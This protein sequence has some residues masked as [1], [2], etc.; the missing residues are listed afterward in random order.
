M[1]N[2][3][4][5]Q[6]TLALVAVVFATAMIVGTFATVADNSAFAGGRSHNG[7]HNGNHHDSSLFAS[8][9]TS[10]N[11]ATVQNSNCISPGGAGTTTG[12]A[13]GAITGACN[14]VATNM[15]INTGTSSINLG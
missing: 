9:D 6:T 14:N 12:G 8:Q 3:T 4:K 5:K 11:S 15:P 10:Q 2:T 7:H 13:G 1:S